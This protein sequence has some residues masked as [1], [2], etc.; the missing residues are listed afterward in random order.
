MQSANVGIPSLCVAVSPD[1]TLAAIGHVRGR[2]TVWDLGRP[3]MHL[4]D[5]RN[6]P[7]PRCVCVCVSLFD[8]CAVVF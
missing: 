1:E 8:D 5:P 2:F 3:E 4:H 6:A 7:F